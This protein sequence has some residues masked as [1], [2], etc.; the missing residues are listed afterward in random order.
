MR[1]L[2]YLDFCNIG[3]WPPAFIT[4]MTAFITAILSMCI[5]ASTKGAH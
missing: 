3:F 5:G 4:G 1:C 2:L